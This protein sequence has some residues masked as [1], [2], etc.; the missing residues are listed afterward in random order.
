MS[1]KQNIYLD[2]NAT[3]KVDKRVFDHMKTYFLN[4]YAIASSQFSHSMGIKAKEAIE[5]SRR[6]ISDKIKA[7]PH[8]IVFTSG[9]TESNNL[10][11]QG[12]ANA[13]K[14]NKRKTIILSPIEHFS[15]LHT[16]QYL[17]ERGF[18]LHFCNI[19]EE[20]FIDMDHLNDLVNESTLLVSI[21]HANHEVGT[22]QDIRTASEIAHRYGAYFHSDISM[23]FGQTDIN[24][25]NIKADMLSF[26]AHKIHGPKG[27]GA[28]YIRDGLNIEKIIHGGFSENNYRA[29]TENVP[30]I[31]GFGKAVEIISPEDI[32]QARSMRNYL[33]EKI[34]KEIDYIKIN[35]PLDFDNRIPN[36]I[37]ISFD[38]IEGESIVLHLDLNGIS[39][40]TGS[41]CF[42][43]SLQASHILMAMGFTHERA[44]SSIR[45][46]TSKYTSKEEIDF[47]IDALK[48]IIR[49]L[50][51]L[52]PLYKKNT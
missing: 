25:E 36:N 10:S 52:S 2:N 24:V 6:I 16:A 49:N 48:E 32:E 31:A 23:S 4:D 18:I 33:Y 14:N 17:R 30:G 21:I 38:Y 37:N 13:N 15:V 8:E 46:S 29:G 1:S 41:A 28:L 19:D 34:R 7:K 40:V 22:I 5:K 35:G 27:C 50:R 20:G 11:I 39:V 45:F 44:H 42:S 12:L 51:M 26:T 9:A 43:K 47:T 3:T